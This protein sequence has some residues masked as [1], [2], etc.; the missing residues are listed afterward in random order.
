MIVCIFSEKYTVSKIISFFVKLKHIM[1]YIKNIQDLMQGF[2]V[3][4]II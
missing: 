3:L 4:E 1:N 2:K